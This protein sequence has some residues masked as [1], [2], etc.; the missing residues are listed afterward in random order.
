VLSAY[1]ITGPGLHL[2]FPMRSQQQPKLRAFIDF[3]RQVMGGEDAPE[4]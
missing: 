2:Y 4:E 3:A 1:G